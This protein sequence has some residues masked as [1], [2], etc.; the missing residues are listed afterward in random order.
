[1]ISTQEV[2]FDSRT[3]RECQLTFTWYC[4]QKFQKF[5]R[6]V[7]KDGL[8]LSSLGDKANWLMPF[9]PKTYIQ[10]PHFRNLI[11]V[12]GGITISNS[13]GDMGSWLRSFSEE[14]NIGTGRVSSN[15]FSKL[16]PVTELNVHVQLY[17][18]SPLPPRPN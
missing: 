7:C 12:Q 1:M 2:S 9:S 11:S 13:E 10:S 18:S 5:S 14:V 15:Q 6:S 4:S 8:L 16:L 17:S 3:K